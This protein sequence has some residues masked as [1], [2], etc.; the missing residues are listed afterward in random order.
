MS[1]AETS[2]NGLGRAT[3]KATI[4]AIGLLVLGCV[5]AN[6]SN[7]LEPLDAW[8]D[9]PVRARIMDFVTRVTT[10]GSA[11][12]VAPADRIAT[13]DMDGTVLTE[14][15]AYTEVIVD[16]LWA[17]VI[18]TNEPR[19]TEQPPFK[20]ACAK[21][22]KY[23][24]DFK[25]VQA[26][27]DAAAGHTQAAYR[28]YTEEALK[29]ARHPGFDRPLGEMVY[30]PMIELARYLQAHE[31]R[32]FFVSGSS[33]PF[34]REMAELRFNLPRTQAIGT[35]WPL[36]FDPN[37]KGVPVFRWQTGK[38]RAPGV[39]GPGK[40]LAILRHI[41]KPPIFAAGNTMGDNEMLLHATKRN[42]PG[43]GIVIVHDDAKREYAYSDPKIQASAKA[44]GWSLVS[45]KKDF[46]VVFTN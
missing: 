43:M 33:Q 14:K 40:P 45:M 7:A 30:A 46:R 19:R 28:K 25:Q 20:Q 42:G 4:L 17:C 27:R 15:P 3:K 16:M 41:G 37:P 18:G 29:L 9:T 10:P 11:D 39:F 23:F 12:F 31:F 22:Y 21:N 34:V 5:Q 32:L 24:D 26:L 13:F 8:S 44:N 1:E 36:V 6:A 35:Q 38:L 2:F